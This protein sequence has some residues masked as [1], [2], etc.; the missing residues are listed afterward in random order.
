MQFGEPH[1]YKIQIQIFQLSENSSAIGGLTFIV[2]L[3]QVHKLL[4]SFKLSFCSN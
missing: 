1:K 2:A 4:L 3:I